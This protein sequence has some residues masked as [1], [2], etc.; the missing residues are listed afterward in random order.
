MS[1]SSD[2]VLAVGVTGHR[3]LGDDPRTPWYVHAQCV[4]ILDRLQ[5]LARY[6]QAR[7]VAYS[8][9]AIGGD[10]LFAWAAI[11]LG[12]PLIGVWPFEA[13][14][15]DFDASERPQF[16]TL[17]QLCAEVHRL[18]RKQR[19][20]R[21]YMAHGKWLVDH[22]DHVVAVWNGLPAAGLGGTGDVVAYAERQGRIVWRIDPALA[23]G[24]G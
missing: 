23:T 11:G 7:L 19:S 5:E 6:R 21:S 12:I 17:N 1:T 10:S 8:G 22:V 18:P 24:D 20:D 2:A 16:D 3:R 9:L 4:R 15:E 13:Y 14:P